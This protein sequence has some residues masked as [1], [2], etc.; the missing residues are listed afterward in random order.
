MSHPLQRNRLLDA[1]RVLWCRGELFYAGTGAEPAGGS[2]ENA[3]PAPREVVVFCPNNHVQCERCPRFHGYRKTP[4]VDIEVS[5]ATLKDLDLL[6]GEGKGA[7]ISDCHLDEIALHPGN[8]NGGID[9]QPGAGAS[10]A[11][12][13]VEDAKR[14]SEQGNPERETFGPFHAPQPTTPAPEEKPQ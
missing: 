7:Q 9:A 12:H 8:I 14:G 11:M 10:P 3:E 6:N 13:G 4:A 2:R 1:W 5:D